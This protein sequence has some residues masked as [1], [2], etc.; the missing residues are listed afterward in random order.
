MRISISRQARVD[1]DA[2]WKYVA[3]KASSIDTASRL[4]T[5]ILKTAS[6]LC[7]SSRLGRARDSDLRAGLRSIPSGNYVIFYRVKGGTSG[8]PESSMENA[9]FQRSFATASYSIS[10]FAIP[11][12]GS[13]ASIPWM[14]FDRAA[15]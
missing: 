8:S 6:L 1:L 4:V 15:R 9:T 3:E 12:R 14:L 13:S 5:S 2:I 10:A 11:R 7:G